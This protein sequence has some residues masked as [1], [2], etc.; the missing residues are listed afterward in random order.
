LKAKSEILVRK[1]AIQ[2]EIKRLSLQEQL[3]VAQ[4]RED[5]S[6]QFDC[7]E[8]PKT[9]TKDE[10]PASAEEIPRPELTSK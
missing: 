4:A 7:I 5:A 9:Y 10:I 8:L 1:Q 3:V 2:N 6:K